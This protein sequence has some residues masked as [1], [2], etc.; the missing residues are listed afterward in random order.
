MFEIYI[1]SFIYMLMIYIDE[2]IYS[3]FICQDIRTLPIKRDYYD[4]DSQN[5][6]GLYIYLYNEK[7]TIKKREYPSSAFYYITPRF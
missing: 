7:I 2:D 1:S 4:C 5:I 6:K 3:L